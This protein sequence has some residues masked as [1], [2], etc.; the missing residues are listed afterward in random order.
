MP[1]KDRTGPF[2]MGPMTGRAAGFCAVPGVAGYMNQAPGGGFGN[3]GRRRVGGFG[4]GGRGWRNRFYATGMT[5]WQR[6]AAGWPVFGGAFP[7]PYPPSGATITGDQELEA[8]KSQAAYFEDALKGI[9]KQIDELQSRN[10]Q[11]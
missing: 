4:G 6:A 5:G 11:D 3:W 8:L 7:N 10:K 2:G 9:Q 1:G